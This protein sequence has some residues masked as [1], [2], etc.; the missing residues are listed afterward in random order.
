MA[1]AARAVE[2]EL[3]GTGISPLNLVSG[4]LM[5]TSARNALRG[6]VSNIVSDA[7]S[8]EIA[9]TVSDEATIYALV[10]TESL[11]ELGLCV[12]RDA[13]VLIKAPFVIVAPGAAPPQT[14][15]RNCI[16][17]T[18][19]RC[20]RLRQSPKVPSHPRWSLR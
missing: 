19:R 8:A 5:K 9:V 15:V 16:R 3:A 17:G 12:G 18:I 7:L 2:P 4:L 14:S 10:T 13:V 1:R 11:R 20:D 6:T